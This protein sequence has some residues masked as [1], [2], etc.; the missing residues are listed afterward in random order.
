M[1]APLSSSDERGLSHLSLD[2]RLRRTF[3]ELPKGKLAELCAR[4]HDESKQRGLLYYR[5]DGAEVINT[6]LCPRGIFPEQ[7]SYFQYITQTVIEAL[8]QIPDLYLQS[9]DVRKVLPLTEDEDRWLRELWTDKHGRQH[10]VFGRMDAMADLTSAS[11]RNALE[12]MEANLT[13]VGG[14]H[15]IP[16]AESVILDVIAP[17]I[18]EIA[19]DLVLETLYDLRDLFMQELRDQARL[20]GRRGDAVA[21]IDTKFVMEGPNEQDALQEYYRQRGQPVFHADPSELYLKGN[22][23]LYDGTPIDICYRDYELR[24]IIELEKSGT[25]VEP[26]KLLFKTNRM[27][28]SMAG[29]FDHKSGFE[30]L[31]D[32][33]WAKYFTPDQQDVFQRHVL[34]T[35]L[36]RECMTTGP[37]GW[38]IDLVEYTRRNRDRLVIKP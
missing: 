34:W 31:T 6:M 22:E 24:D 32:P 23:V 33:N 27:V 30:I 19:P 17:A 13:G 28:S 7:S 10:S 26:L 35:R 29:D 14:V 21:L 5:E 3:I 38:P 36:V 1:S 2:S 15:L 25:N 4:V 37:E 20:M 16:T 12:F 8:K 11:W 18:Q 9:E